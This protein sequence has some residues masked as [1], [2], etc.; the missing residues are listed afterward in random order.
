MRHKSCLK[1]HKA[2]NTDISITGNNATSKT[3]QISIYPD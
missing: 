2:D 1:K 3:S